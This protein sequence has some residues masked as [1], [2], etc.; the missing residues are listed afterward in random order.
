MHKKAI[1]IFTTIGIFLM[2]CTAAAV[3]DPWYVG[4]NAGAVWLMDS[5]IKNGTSGEASFDTGFGAGGSVGYDFGP[6]R[7]EG[8]IE[9]RNNDYDKAG[10]DGATKE[11]SGGSY[12][13]LALMVNGYYDFE[14]ASSFTPFLMAGIG[15]ANVDTDSV[16]SGGL[17]IASDNSWQFAYQVGA[18]VGWEFTDSWILDVSY[19]FFGTTNPSFGGSDMQYLSHNL[20]LGIR[21]SF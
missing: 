12:Q 6:A 17:N 5:D 8:E 1:A 11:K 9:Y 19:R 10:L 20:F 2:V 7:L 3:A 14:N 4:V 21:Y 15:G 16:T 13:S 18:G